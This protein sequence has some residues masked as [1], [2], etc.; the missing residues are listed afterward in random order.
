P[1]R[2]APPVPILC[3]SRVHSE[4]RGGQPR[5]LLLRTRQL[6]GP[7]RSSRSLRHSRTGSTRSG[8]FA[9]ATCPGETAKKAVNTADHSEPKVVRSLGRL[10][11]S[12]TPKTKSRPL[13]C[14]HN[15]RTGGCLEHARRIREADGAD[16]YGRDMPPD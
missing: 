2:L 13:P 12:Q 11:Y 8:R 4:C 6:A 3:Q 5:C 9:A 7:V 10:Q 14:A 16:V 1:P 15:K